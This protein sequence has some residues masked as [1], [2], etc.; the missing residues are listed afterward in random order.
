MELADLLDP[1]ATGEDEGIV[2][3]WAYLQEHGFQT[4]D[5]KMMVGHLVLSRFALPISEITEGIQ[6]LGF[7]IPEGPTFES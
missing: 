1:D 2:S 6:E 7:T 4:S 5:I 3:V